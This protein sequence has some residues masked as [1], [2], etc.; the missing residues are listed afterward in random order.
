VATH[1]SNHARIMHLRAALSSL[2]DTI[3]TTLL[4]LATTRQEL[5]S[6]AYTPPADST[7]RAVGYKELLSYAK[8]VAYTSIPPP[9]FVPPVL[10][11]DGTEEPKTEQTGASG[12]PPTRADAN[13]IY[14][15]QNKL[16]A[17]P[18][19]ELQRMKE[20]EEAKAGGWTPWVGDEVIR[21]GGLAGVDWNTTGLNGDAAK[22]DVDEVDE[23]KEETTEDWP[24][25][26]NT[27]AHVAKEQPAKEKAVFGGLDLYDPEDD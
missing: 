5:Q 1:Q 23:Q 13:G 11:G 22:K 26:S 18:A 14:D 10:S 4:T 12:G 15:R 16:I 20:A 9:G 27:V 7:I 17:L 3:R 19:E 25:Q 21:A 8:K 24:G 6:L 2:D